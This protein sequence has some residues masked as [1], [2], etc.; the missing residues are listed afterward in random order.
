MLI[1]DN[2]LTGDECT[3]IIANINE[4]NECPDGFFN[5]VFA[6][7][8]NILSTKVLNRLITH[9]LDFCDSVISSTW[10]YTLYKN[11]ECLSPHIDGHKTENNM[12]SYLT[13]LIY[14][15]HNFSGGQTIIY[16]DK[17]RAITSIQPQIGKALIMSQDVMHESKIL[18]SGTKYVIRSDIM[19]VI[20][21]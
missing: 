14:L 17:S 18:T 16:Q 1:Y 15:N 3:E 9:S 10:F 13:I 4:L 12:K 6:I 11:G 21:E 20:P 7:K 8:N 2:L 5:R 19:R